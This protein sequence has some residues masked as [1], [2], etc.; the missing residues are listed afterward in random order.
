MLKKIIL[1]IVSII[2]CQGAGFIG[3]IF[4]TPKI[5]SWFAGLI[6]PS[7]NPPN[8]IFA[9]VWT[10]LFLLMGIAL[11]LVI[12][13]KPL[14]KFALI[15]FVVQLILNILWSYLFFGLQNPMIAF[16]EIIILW[17]AILT[18]IYLFWPINKTAAYLLIPYI[19]W[20]SFASVL[21]FSLWRLN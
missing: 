14:P 2:I 19:A 6:K 17:L 8:W 3:S 5:G 20:V 16:M 10:S 18:T 7:F 9:P 15:A 11:F 4:T 21:N 12:Q 1:L 13:G